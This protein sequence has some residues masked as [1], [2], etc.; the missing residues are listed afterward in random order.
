MFNFK[1]QFSRVRFKSKGIVSRRFEPPSIENSPIWPS[2]YISFFPTT[3]F[4]K[5]FS[6]NITSMKYRRS[7]NKHMRE[8]CFFM[9][10][11][12]QTITRFF[13]KQHLNICRSSHQ[14]CSVKKVFLEISQNSQENTCASLFLNKTGLQLY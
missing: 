12:L 1:F 7:K 6:G 11:R 8:S 5:H 4:W 3:H 9:F 14:R 13:Y 2:P 10:K